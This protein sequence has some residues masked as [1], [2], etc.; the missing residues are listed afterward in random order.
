MLTL[1][2]W[3]TTAVSNWEGVELQAN[4][5][6]RETVRCLLDHKTA[7]ADGDRGRLH[8]RRSA[9]GATTWGRRFGCPRGWCT[10]RRSAPSHRDHDVPQC[11]W[12]LIITC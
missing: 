2:P 1:H 3:P 8:H 12:Q 9:V 10:G 4:L 7:I 6:C 5:R 11:F